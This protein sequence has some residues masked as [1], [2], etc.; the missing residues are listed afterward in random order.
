[1]NNPNPLESDMETIKR[2]IHFRIPMSICNFRC[3]YCYLSHRDSAYEGIQPVMNYTPSQVGYALRKERLGGAA[4]I[5]MCGDGET[6]LLRDL[7]AYLFNFL[8]EGHYVEVVTNLTITPVLE[9][10]LRFPKELLEHLEFKCSFHYSELKSKNKLEVFAENVRK[11][12]RSGAS[13][14]VELTPSDELIPQIDEIMEFSLRNFG[15]FPHVTIARDDRTKEIGYLTALSP[16]EFYK[17][18]QRFNSSFLNFKKSIFGRRQTR[19]C[20]AGAWS[21]YIDLCTGEARQCYCGKHLGNLFADPDS[22]LPERPV[23]KCPLPHCYNGHMLLTLGLIPANNY[24]GYGDLRDR[25]TLNGQHW[26]NPKFK[27]FINTELQ[28][29]NHPYSL[30]KRAVMCTQMKI[31]DTYDALRFR[32]GRLKRAALNR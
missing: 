3:S 12:W 32:L 31:A 17:H 18:W 30:V 21:Y 27:Q 4:Y 14:C 28:Q 1:M 7:P 10:I 29:S 15:A 6:L 5:N 8:T 23:G 11:I 22:P 25:T 2:F 26:L 9:E 24:P 16:E 13:A 20:Y 19:F